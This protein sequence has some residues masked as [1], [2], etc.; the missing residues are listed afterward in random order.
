[1]IC[2][3][4]NTG[5]IP[6]SKYSSLVTCGAPALVEMA[7]NSTGLLGISII[8][9]EEILILFVKPVDK[10]VASVE[11]SMAE[12]HNRVDNRHVN[13]QLNFFIIILIIPF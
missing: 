4:N 11:G 8:L 1:M 9:F 12:M 10:L 7:G 6:E 13:N 2:S 3:F 5:I